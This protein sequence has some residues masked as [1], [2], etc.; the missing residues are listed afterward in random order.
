M[1]QRDQWFSAESIEEQI[2]QHLHTPEQSSANTRMLHDLQHVA[3]GDVQRLAH[4]RGRLT[5]HIAG[6]TKRSP[7]PLQRYQHTTIPPLHRI[8]QRSVQKRQQVLVKLLS[9]IVAV[10]VFAS[11]LGVFTVL[12][13]HPAQ[14][15][16]NHEKTRSVTPVV[17][18]IAAFLLDASSGKVLVDVNSHARL[19]IGSTAKIMTAVVA[20]ENANLDQSV[21]IEQATLNEMPAG[22][23][24]A[25]LQVGDQ[26]Q[27]RELLYALLLPSGD[28]AAFVIAH[29]VAGDTQKFVAMMNDEA[30]QLQLNDTHF[31]DPYGSPTP[32]DYSSAANLTRLARFALQLSAFAQTVATQEHV[33]T[34]TAHNHRYHW[35]TTN[36][37]LM[38]YPGMNGSKTGYDAGACMVFS[39]QRSGRLLIGTELHAQSEAIL[40]SDVKKL[41]D[42]GFA[43]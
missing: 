14:R 32:D 30:Q 24:T 39:A 12:R 28:D 35:Q 33:L 25:Q 9:G 41:L 21:T 11:M 34:A 22:M 4:I 27:L 18:G 15:K 16:A 17:H 1:D 38:S 40:T 6:N 19:S 10:L 43:S 36:T 20:I 3:E 5:E 23:S 29:A 31:S 2:E 13:S 26:V 7:V 42:H 8:D 37:L